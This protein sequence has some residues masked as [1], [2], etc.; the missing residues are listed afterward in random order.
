ML[1]S[2]AVW[3]AHASFPDAVVVTDWLD[4][5][6]VLDACVPGLEDQPD[7]RHAVSPASFCRPLAAPSLCRRTAAA[8]CVWPHHTEAPNAQLS[9]QYAGFL[10]I[11]CTE[12]SVRPPSGV[13]MWQV[14]H[15][16]FAGG[17]QSHSSGEE[18]TLTARRLVIAL[19]AHCCFLT[20]RVLPTLKLVGF[21]SSDTNWALALESL[22]L[23]SLALESL[24]RV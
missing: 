9:C 15:A 18:P 6:L 16:L 21:P 23:E 2:P 20:T 17:R 19:P 1:E 13:G 11:R 5:D 10:N 24:A 3:R 8:L 14:L 12:Y 7:M 22:G 4:F